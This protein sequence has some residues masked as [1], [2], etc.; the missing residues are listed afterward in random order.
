MAV[1][2]RATNQ[3]RATPRGTCLGFRAFGFVFLAFCGLSLGPAS[4]LAQPSR[5][6]AASA[7]AGAAA[8]QGRPNVLQEISNA[9][10]RIAERTTP[11]VVGIWVDI[12]PGAE[13]TSSKDTPG[14]PES[15]DGAPRTE[16]RGWVGKVQMRNS[17]LEARNEP[18]ELPP[19]RRGPAG[20]SEVPPEQFPQMQ[21]HNLALGS[22]FIVAPDG[23]ILTNNHVVGNAD[24][25]MVIVGDDN[26]VRAEV[27]GTDPATDLAVIK[28]NG[29]DHLPVLQFADSDKLKVGDWVVAIGQPF[30]LSHTVTS[31]IISA[32]GR[33][34]MDLNTYED[35]I[36][37]DA[38][39][40]P[41]NS[42]GPLVDLDGR[43]IG[44]N[45]A[46]LGAAGNIGI[47]FAIPAN[48]VK[49]VYEQ[50]RR[51]GKVARGFLGINMQDLTPRLAA[52]FG[53]PADT[54]GIL[55]SHVEPNSPAAA[56]LRP[57]DILV[58]FD[59]KPAPNAATLATQVSLLQP[60]SKVS[61]VL[62]R[63]G[64]RK[65]ITLEMG[66]RPA[67][68]PAAQQH[69][70][71]EVLG[72]AVEDLTAD[73]AQRLNYQGLTGVLVVAVAENSPAGAARIAQG[74]LIQE[75]NRRPVKNLSEFKAVMEEAVQKPPVLFLVD[76]Q[77]SYR[78]LVMA[79]P[80][81]DQ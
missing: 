35:F 57:G 53:A 71:L 58:Q 67:P 60:D 63:N 1:T 72:M 22:G 9:V 54:K 73:L 24:L 50:L 80:S 25:V 46:I 51:N 3:G 75:V 6:V 77:G 13:Q 56:G 69:P 49:N 81:N 64:A 19:T 78:Y 40:N 23:Y 10:A 66:T 4:S 74:M 26:P 21:R 8:S 79:P 76:Y 11:A 17:T 47:G 59:G 62:L 28:V 30:G 18:R 29:Y 48:M 15:R 65:S 44:V 2:G 42:G 45:T 43:V 7:A 36:Q 70:A 38:P 68:Q 27:V 20:P 5:K 32:L 33:T 34:N 41:G 55:V 14:W 39:I 52:L 61:I 31:G 37:T 16:V 12:P